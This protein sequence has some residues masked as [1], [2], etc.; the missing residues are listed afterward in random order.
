MVEQQILN[1]ILV[2]K[3]EIPDRPILVAVDGR[4][5]SGKS[6]VAAWLSASVGCAVFSMDDFFLQPGM[7]TEERLA[8]PGGNVDH[9]R[10][11][12]E[13]LA[14]LSQGER[15]ISWQPYDCG[16]QC[17]LKGRQQATCPINIIEG[18]SKGRTVIIRSSRRIMICV[19]F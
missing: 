10:F 8:T 12:K 6:T 18:A 13:V 17:L 15:L 7:R 5:A 11:L 4:C 9:A 16:T 3:A 19:S 2:K 14:P 1:R